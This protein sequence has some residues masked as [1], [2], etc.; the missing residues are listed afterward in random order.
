MVNCGR[1]HKENSDTMKSTVAFP[2]CTIAVSV[3][4]LPMLQKCRRD[5]DGL[6]VHG[7]Q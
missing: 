5:L 1:I 2:I 3:S 6:Y 7:C 4:V